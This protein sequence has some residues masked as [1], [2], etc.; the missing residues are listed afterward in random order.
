MSYRPFFYSCHHINQHS[1]FCG[2]LR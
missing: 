2:H 1:T